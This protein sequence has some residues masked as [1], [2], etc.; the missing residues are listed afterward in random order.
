MIEA[1][2]TKVL[3]V[4]VV[5]GMS[6]AGRSTALHALE[7]LG[8]FCID[9]LPA[10]LALQVLEGLAR[11]AELKRVGL[12]MDVRTG[13]FLKG[14][15]EVIDELHRCG[16][17][18]EVVFLDCAD[19]VLV[20]RYSETRRPHPLAP[21]GD[22][23]EAIQ[24]ERERLGELRSRASRV[25]DTS[26]LSV[27]QL[28]RLL[29][30]QFLRF[31]PGPAM[32]TRLISFGFKYGLPIDA[33]LVFDLRYLPNPHFVAELRPHSGI[34][35]K[36]ADYVLAASESRELLD[37]L[38]KLL[39]LVLPKYEKEGKAYL[40]VAFGCTGGRHRS[41]AFVEAMAQRLASAWSVAKVHRDI[42][43]VTAR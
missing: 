20:R 25:V 33:D 4:V 34:E 11:E 35:P 37:E 13:S 16:H 41:V 7:D 39:R 18:V 21:S 8:F 26:S 9:N 6:G 22:V 19:E 2:T 5:T 43:K 10:R 36:V 42:D 27:H 14:A 23:L 28:K 12:G 38:E 30:E 32:V 15:G 3:Q 24:R 40:N 17:E 29:S 1:T 31:G